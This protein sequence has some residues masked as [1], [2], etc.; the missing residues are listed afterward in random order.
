MRKTIITALVLGLIAGA[1]TAP[2]AEAKRKRYKKTVSQ[3]YDAPAIGVSN[4]VY[5]GGFSGC[6][7]DTNIGCVIFTTTAKAKYAKVTVV[8]S[9]GN[10]VGGFVSQGDVDGDGIGDGFGSFCGAHTAP[11]AI[12]AGADLEVNFYPGVCDDGA[13]PSTPTTGEVKVTFTDR[14]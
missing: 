1:L 7:G 5:T 11:V 4:P 9:S 6:D 13:T 12:T 14:P 8:D 3:A 10:K 2:M